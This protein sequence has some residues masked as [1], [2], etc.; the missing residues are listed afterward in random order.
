MGSHTENGYNNNN[1]NNN[2][3]AYQPGLGACGA[4]LSSQGR[5]VLSNLIL[6]MVGRIHASVQTMVC[7]PVHEH[8]LAEV[9]A[10]RQQLLQYTPDEV[11]QIP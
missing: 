3:N 11:L 9:K 4:S 7:L 2:Y 5:L 8:V 10:Q 1:N 6:R